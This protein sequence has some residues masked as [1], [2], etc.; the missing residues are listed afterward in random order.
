VVLDVGCGDGLIAFGALERVGGNGQVIF[1]DI[2]ADL[3]SRCRTTAEQLSVVDHCRFLV[4]AATDLRD[5]V[6]ASVDVITARS[7]LIYVDDKEAAFREFYRVLR[8]G[9][10]IAIGEPINQFTYPEPPGI[11]LGYDLSPI[12]EL[13]DKLRAYFDRVERAKLSSMMDFNERDLLRLVEDAGFREIELNLRIEVRGTRRE[14]WD[15]FVKTAGNPLSPTL[16]QAMAASLTPDETATLRAQL[17]PRVESG[18]GTERRAFA[19]LKA[20]KAGG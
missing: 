8:P 9:G 2:S 10:R 18:T 5:L 11:F 14:S 7:V 19:F 17:K 20:R 3:I 16:K 6:D 13:A 1:S 4:A 15:R 12:A